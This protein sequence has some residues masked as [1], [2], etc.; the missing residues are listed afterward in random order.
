[1]T[2]L[3]DLLVPLER[4]PLMYLC[5]ER[6]ATLA[7]F[8]QGHA[9]ASGSLLGFR[10]WLV[11]RVGSGFNLGWE[12]LVLGLVFPDAADPWEAL[13]FGRGEREACSTLLRL[14]GEFL[15]ES[16]HVEDLERRYADLLER[17]TADA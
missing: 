2:S 15:G 7:A 16:A 5:D 11:L 8:L 9:V 4:H 14:V 6:F 10:E 17:S 13:R 12:A 1:M 3:V